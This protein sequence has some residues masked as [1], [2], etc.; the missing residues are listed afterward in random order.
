MIKKIAVMLAL[1]LAVATA[2]PAWA[3]NKCEDTVIDT[4]GILKDLGRVDSVARNMSGAEVRVRI[5]PNFGSSGNLDIYEKAAEKECPS[6]LAPDGGR[7]NN[8]IV[9]MASMKEHKMGLYFRRDGLYGALDNH[10][11]RIQQGLMAPRF[12][13][14]DFDGGVTA[15]LEEV[16]RV[17]DE[18]IHPALAPPP[19]TTTAQATVPV[20]IPTAPSQPMDLSWVG[21]AIKWTGGLAVGLFALIFVWRKREEAAQKQ[22][23]RLSARLRAKS[24]KQRVTSEQLDLGPKLDLLEARASQSVANLAPDDAR[25]L[26]SF[27]EEVRRQFDTAA[28]SYAGLS[29]SANNPDDDKLSEVEYNVIDTNLS[30]AMDAFTKVRDGFS[31][32]ERRIAEL[33]DLPNQV[34]AV[35]ARIAVV[36]DRVVAAKQV[37]DDM[38]RTY[39]SGSWESVRGNGTEATNRINWALKALDTAKASL[40]AKPRQVQKVRTAIEDITKWLDA[41]ESMTQSIHARREQLDIAMRDLPSTIDSATSDLAAARKYIAANRADL[42][43]DHSTEL[44][45]A[46]SQLKVARAEASKPGLDVLQALK[47]AQAVHQTIDNIL[48][49]VRSEHDAAERRRTRAAA[50]LR[51]AERA[52]SKAREY[53]EDHSEEVDDDNQSS[54]ERT[55]ALLKSAKSEANLDKQTD[56]ALMAYNMANDTYDEVKSSVRRKSRQREYSTAGSGYRSGSSSNVVVWGTP[57]NNHHSYSTSDDSDSG[58]VWSPSPSVGTSDDGGSSSWTSSNVSVSDGGGS[59][60]W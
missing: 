10:W 57:S 51:D 4:A 39:A 49:G 7:K 34:R 44:D 37:F 22:S 14:G 56:Q 13:S 59:T 1:I 26:M 6:W 45:S 2:T 31:E 8:L 52:I 53:F 29:R 55:R 18:A 12:R 30:G 15:A 20:Y 27:V 19:A 11:M 42:S 58:S 60:G 17:T 9:L 48:D 46:E 32:V 21:S 54:L 36:Q 25:G 16:K 47:A 43:G 24:T 41:A 35:E 38:S 50:A 3:Q 23:N 40:S 33:N 5:I 28:A